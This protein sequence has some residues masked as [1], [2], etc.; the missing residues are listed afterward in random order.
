MQAAI[1]ASRRPGEARPFCEFKQ[2]LTKFTKIEK[3]LELLLE[4]YLELTL[5][6]ELELTQETEVV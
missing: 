1:G 4:I 5:E 6:I 2:Y 3:E